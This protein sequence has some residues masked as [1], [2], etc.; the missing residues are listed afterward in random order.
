MEADRYTLQV[1]P[2]D[3]TG[4]TLCVEVCPVK[5]KSDAGR[6]AINMAPQAPLREAVIHHSING[7][8]AI[9]QGSWKLE[10]CP[11]SGGWAEPKDPAARKQG[12]PEV[13]L[14]D[15]TK[16]EGEQ[17]NLEAPPPH[18]FGHHPIER[19]LL[20]NRNFRIHAPDRRA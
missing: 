9:R 6:K 10:L 17:H 11:G 12:L 15:M 7:M 20:G 13:Q 1:A 18:R 14:Y 5:N 3:C 4:C 2:E 19:A 16:D 8:F